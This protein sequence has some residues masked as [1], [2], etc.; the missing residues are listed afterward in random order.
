MTTFALAVP[1]RY[2]PERRPEITYLSRIDNRQCSTSPTA[3]KGNIANFEKSPSAQELNRLY[4][5]TEGE[6]FHSG[7]RVH[8]F[9][10]ELGLFEG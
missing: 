4:C 9:N 8:L 5:T 7:R 1:G 2:T 6:L 3:A 10:F